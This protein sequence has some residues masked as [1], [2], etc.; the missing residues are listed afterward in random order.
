MADNLGKFLDPKDLTIVTE[1][2][3]PIGK[4]YARDDSVHMHAKYLGEQCKFF[5]TIDSKYGFSKIL[6]PAEVIAQIQSMSKNDREVITILTT[7]KANGS[8]I[9]PE[10]GLN[11]MELLVRTW[12]LANHHLASDSFPLLVI[13]NLQHNIKAGGGC[14]AGISARLTQPYCNF[15]RWV[16]EQKL[17]EQYMPKVPY[18]VELSIAEIEA[19][20]ASMEPEASKPFVPSYTASNT[21][22][23]FMASSTELSVAEIEAQFAVLAVAS[24]DDDLDPETKEQ[25]RNAY[26]ENWD[27]PYF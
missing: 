21:A 26:G 1:K 6:D 19:Q 14:L 24:N 15:I 22:A 3:E 2:L 17:H 27:K 11:V 13:E 5:L 20:F 23:Q 4:I 16:L 7:I 12:S 18:L 25:L 8:I 10:T 9:E